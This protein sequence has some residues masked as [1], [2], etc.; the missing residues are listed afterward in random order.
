MNYFHRMIQFK[1]Q[2][3]RLAKVYGKV[4]YLW[5]ICCMFQDPLMRRLERCHVVPVGQIITSHSQYTIS[6]SEAGVLTVGTPHQQKGNFIKRWCTYKY[7]NQ[8]NQLATE[9]YYLCVKTLSFYRILFLIDVGAFII[10]ETFNLEP[11]KLMSFRDLGSP[12]CFSS[13]IFGTG[14]TI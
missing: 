7:R 4:N 1:L 8:C 12:L 9:N 2:T 10:L 14:A 11:R 3:V 13:S 6:G 5:S